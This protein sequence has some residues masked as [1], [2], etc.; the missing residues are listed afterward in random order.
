MEHLLGSPRS[1]QGDRPSPCV[2][3]V[4]ADA[5]DSAPGNRVSTGHMVAE[6]GVPQDRD[7]G[8]PVFSSNGGA[9]SPKTLSVWR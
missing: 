2:G 3:R 1:S 7:T 4:S 5:R 9:D 6:G 8:G